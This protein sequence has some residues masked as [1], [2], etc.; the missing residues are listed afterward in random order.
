MPIRCPAFIFHIEKLGSF[1]QAFLRKSFSAVS[2]C[3]NQL[4]I[5]THSFKIDSPAFWCVICSVRHDVHQRSM[6]QLFVQQCFFI[7]KVLFLQH[8]VNRFVP[9]VCFS[10]IENTFD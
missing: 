8:N 5:R 7:F 6:K 2:D 10:V 4:I 9:Y 1:L 3:E